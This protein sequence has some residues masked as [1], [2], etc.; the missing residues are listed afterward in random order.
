LTWR[1]QRRRRSVPRTSIFIDLL[2]L[3]LTLRSERHAQTALSQ[4]GTRQLSITHI[5]G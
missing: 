4:E 1:L 3:K 5:L 2:T